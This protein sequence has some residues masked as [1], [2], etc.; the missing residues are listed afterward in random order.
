MNRLAVFIVG[1]FLS[2]AVALP[3]KAADTYAFDKEGRHYYAG[4]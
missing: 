1:A 2:I 3:A 4:F